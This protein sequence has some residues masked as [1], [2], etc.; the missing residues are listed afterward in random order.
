L[1]KYIEKLYGKSAK[2]LTESEWGTVMEVFQKELLV[3]IEKVHFQRVIFGGGISLEQ[4]A[5]LQQMAKQINN[6]KIT[7]ETSGLGEDTGLL[8]AFALIL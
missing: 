6:Y 4:S 7:L 2:L 8:G 5:R 3:F 1:G